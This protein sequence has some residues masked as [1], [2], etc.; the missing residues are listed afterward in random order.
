MGVTLSVIVP[1]LNGGKAFEKCMAALSKST[2]KPL[3]LWV[4]DDGSGDGSDELA[5]KYGARV[6]YTG[7]RGSGP[8]HARNLAAQQAAGDILF[9]TDADCAVHPDTL[10]RALEVFDHTDAPDAVMGCYDLTPGD[11]GFLSQYK[12]LFH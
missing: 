3:E 5:R 9:F 12:N 11:P 10:E 1:V 8:A 6:L 4:V 2:I 7:K